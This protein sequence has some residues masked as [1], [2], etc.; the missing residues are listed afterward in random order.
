MRTRANGAQSQNVADFAKDHPAF[1]LSLPDGKGVR[2]VR[3]GAA[4]IQESSDLVFPHAVHLDPAGVRHPDKDKVK[5]ELRGLPPARR[6][7]ARLR[8]RV[9]GAGTARIATACEFEP[10]VTTPRRCRT[11][12]PAEAMTVVREFYANLALNG[13][14]DSFEK[15]FGVPGEGLLRRAGEPTP[16]QRQAALGMAAKK[17]AHVSEEI[18][19]I[20]LCRTCHEIQQERGRHRAWTG[21]WPGS[22]R[23][24]RGC[25]RR[26]STTRATRRRS[27]PTATTW[28]SR[29]EAPTWR[30]RRSRAA[31]NATAARGP[32]RRR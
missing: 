10:A 11:A 18:F 3:Q 19:E 7:E 27:A 24:A 21:T 23:T 20:R 14:Q 25:R 15:A 12:G 30:C 13:V 31:A 4:P 28:R 5:L 16:A 17:A 22:A 2:R 9:D 29:S 6:L 32:P 8:A 26:A 1:R